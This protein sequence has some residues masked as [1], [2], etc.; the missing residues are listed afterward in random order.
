MSDG[1]MSEPIAIIGMSSK[2]AGEATDNEGLWRMLAN[3]RSGWTPFPHSR[4]G[5]KGV[6]H[7]NNERLNSTHVKGAHFLEEDVG[8]FDAN[9]FGYSA[10]TA[11]SLD[12]QYRLQLESV[13][14]AIE[15]AG[16]PLAQIA[17]SNTSVFTGV[18][19]HDYR[20]GLLRDA[21]NLPRLMATGTG[22]PMMSN[23]I[24][25]FFDLHGTSMT[26]ET[27]CSSGMVA[28]HQG[29][30]SLRTH[31]ADLSIVGGANLTLNPDMFK[32]LSSSGFLSG[33]GKCYAFDSRASGYGRGEGVATLLIKRLREALADGDPI[34][35]VIRESLLNQDGRTETITAPSVEAQEALIRDCYRRAGLLFGGSGRRRENPLLMGSIKTN[36]GHTEA[37][38]GLASIIKTALAMERGVIPPSINFEKPNPKIALDDWNLKLVTELVNWPPGSSR[39]ASVNNF[40]AGGPN[41]KFLVNLAY[42][43]GQ[44]RSR[45]SCV[46]VY[47]VPV[48]K[49]VDAVVRALDSP[50]FKPSRNS[51][52]PRIGMVF[53]GQGAQWYATSLEMAGAYL[54]EFTGAN[55]SLLEELSRDADTSRINEVALSTPICIAIAAAYAAGAL[56]F[57]EAMAVSYYRAVLAAG[58][59]PGRAPGKEEGAMIA[60]GLGVD[61]T[62]SYLRRLTQAN[63]K[64]VVACINSPSSTTVS[65]DVSAV[66]ELEELANIDGVFARRLRIN[67]AWHSHHMVSVAEAYIESI[68]RATTPAGK[69]DAT[70]RRDDD[71]LVAFSS[72]VTVRKTDALGSMQALAAGLLREGYPVDMDAVNFPHGRSQQDIKVLTTLPLY[73]WNHQNKHWIEPRF[74]RA[75]RARSEPPHDLLGSLVD[76]SNPDAPS[77]RHILRITDAPWTQ[78]HVIQSSIVF[79][80]AGYI[81]LAIEAVRQLSMIEGAS[82]RSISGYR[83]RDID[84]MQALLIPSSSDGIEIQTQLRTASNRDLGA[85]GWKHFEVWT[86]TADNRWTQHAKGL[87]SVEFDKTPTAE[88]VEPSGSGSGSSHSVVTMAIPDTSVPNDLVRDPVVHPVTLDSIITAPYS[89]L[90]AAAA[91]QATAKVPRA[92]ESFW[93]SSAISHSPGHLL[94]AHSWLV[95]DD[96]QGMEAGVSV[97]DHDSG[98]LVLEMGRFS[99]QSLGRGV[100]SAQQTTEPW[101]KE[102]NSLVKWAPDIS[103]GSPA[104]FAFLKKQLSLKK[105]EDWH[106]DVDETTKIWQICMSFMQQAIANLDSRDADRVEPRYAKYY[107]W[108]VDTVQQAAS[109]QL[110]IGGATWL[111]DKAPG[112]PQRH[113]DQETGETRNVNVEIV[114]RLGAHLVD[115]LRGE[116]PPLPLMVQ[117]NLLARFYDN[118]PALKRTG[119][120]LSGLLAHL[121]HKNPRARILEIG[122]GTGTMTRFALSALGTPQSGG[123]AADSYHYTD[124]SAALFD[125]ARETLAPWSDLLVF[126]VLDPQREPAAQ[127]FAHGTYDVVIASGVVSAETNSVSRTLGSARNLLKPGGVLLLTEV[128]QDKVL[129]PFVQALLLPERQIESNTVLAT[130]VW[131][132]HLR[133]AGFSGVSLELRDCSDSR[134]STSVTIMS[135]VPLPTLP[136][137]YVEPEN[138]L[139]VTSRRAAPPPVPW[140]KG[141]Q[142]LI[143]EGILGRGNISVATQD[144]ESATA[145]SYAHKFCIFIGEVNKPILHDLDP[146]ALEGIQTMCTACK[147]LLWLTRGGAVDC[148]RPEFSLASGFIR[149][150]R[151]EHV[152]RRLLTLDLDPAGAPWSDSSA[153]AIVQVLRAALFDKAEA[154]SIVEPEYAERDGVMLVPRFYHDT[155]RDQVLSSRGVLEPGPGPTLEPA[156][157][158]SIEPFHQQDRLLCLRPE[159]LAFGDD[160]AGATYHDSP[161]PP[162]LL[163]VEPRAYGVSSGPAD[164]ENHIRGLECA[165]IVTRVGSGAAV[166]DYKVGDSVVCVLHQEKQSSFP[167][168]VA[169]E[170]TATVHKPAN[171]SFQEAVSVPLAFLTAYF[172]LVEVA[173]LQRAQWVLIHAAAEPTGQAAIMIAQHVEAKVLAT[174]GNPEQRV[175][176]TEK[177]GIPAESI[178][179]LDTSDLPSFESTILAAT[180]GHG[181]D[182]VLNS[183]GGPLLQ[184]SFNLVAPFGHFVEVSGRDS[185]ANSNLEMRPFSRSISFTSVDLDLMLEHRVADVHRC[186]REI[187]RMIE[188][189][190]FA[191]VHPIVSYALGD[192]L[193]ASRLLQEKSE[194]RFTG[195]V[196]LSVDQDARVPVLQVPRR[197]KLAG[198]ASYLIVGGNGGLGQ[199]VAHWMASRGA[200]NLILLSRSASKSGKMVALVKEL[201]ETGCRV[202]PVDCDIADEDDL[203]QAVQKS[204]AEGLPPIRGIVHAAFV[205]RDAFVEKMTFQDWK[206]TTQSKVAGAWNLHSCFNLPDDLDFF[207]L[208]SSINGLL[209]Y[210]SQAAYSAGGAYEDALA[211]WRVKQCGLPAVSIDLPVVDTVGYVAEASSSEKLRRSLIKAG[212]RPIDVNGVLASLESAIQRPFDPQFAVGINSGPGSHWDVDGALGRDPRSLALKYRPLTQAAAQQQQQQQQ[213][214]LEEEGGSLAAKMTACTSRDDGIR[215]VGEAIA[216]VLAEMFLVPVEDIDLTESPAHQGVD[217][218]MAVELRNVLFSQAGAEISIFNIMQAPSLVSLA[219]AVVG[220]SRYIKF[221]ADSL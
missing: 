162:N 73:P 96:S 1:W 60:V 18:F 188:V 78:D 112:N 38:S 159:T 153:S 142:A 138:V 189:R 194:P 154:G 79:P 28:L 26:I 110:C 86:V 5:S 19:V 114:C 35:A 119:S 105:T 23:R 62:E 44:R 160:E 43:L 171:L 63:G 66:K 67:T 4:F 122:A 164:R 40:G 33:D 151:T 70:A 2:F 168:R 158:T 135:T 167:N 129:V 141:L 83:L 210:A 125:T 187:M 59:H 156:P 55:W 21:D 172:S 161:L 124:A 104:T 134:A 130:D 103:T 25:H 39:R 120:Q 75:L 216:E 211:H 48:T 56:S 137:P 32:A 98:S 77:W 31:E 213:Q 88:A 193:E 27:A 214:S 136:E 95:R 74:N 140:L 54:E 46:A 201:R 174:V 17:G 127:G 182:V 8:L 50:A 173:R 99:Y 58:E 169:V 200:R 13:Y 53:T 97:F 24:S 57:R 148:E 203:A 204:A 152:A 100:A 34:R 94:R 208:F 191:P 199:S 41:R 175:T 131:D 149:T 155:E 143:G 179:M 93:V 176:L 12:P 197:A 15:S 192:V 186:L 68:D 91:R 45:Y 16:L 71:H 212:H 81:C 101:E 108:L 132:R 206:D 113:M 49:G 111:P 30:Q 65:G 10:E 128:V 42:T 183:L 116:V 61:E 217:S 80:A 76:G 82:D 115:I 177:Y 9:F 185:K 190:A 51:R 219:T 109:G 184:H 7:P 72:P 196:V 106:D 178:F 64:A 207:V 221:A 157:K 6:Y 89:T 102:L 22:V 209:G 107:A 139:I 166:Q 150:L 85:R 170:P 29:I 205:L 165:G 36:I 220:C 117:D 215:V 20:D 144:L 118:I 11:S 14:E 181:V 90:S 84:F 121:V 37:A 218:L 163:E 47:P 202:L 126:D 69:K 146:A 147:G 123:P 3:G 198:D 92:V 133:D 87:V 52:R 180:Q 145:S 195:K